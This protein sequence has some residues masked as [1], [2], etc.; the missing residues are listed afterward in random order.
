MRLVATVFVVCIVTTNISNHPMSDY[1]H[2]VIIFIIL[3]GG[4]TLV[5]EEWSHIEKKRDFS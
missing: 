5:E 4:I 1:A 3:S 2:R